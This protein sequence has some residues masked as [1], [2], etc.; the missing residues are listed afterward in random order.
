MFKWGIITVMG[1]S[2][3]IE[4]C[5]NLK[6][7]Q[8]D[9]VLTNLYNQHLSDLDLKI[10][11]FSVLRALWLMKTAAQ[12]QLEKVLLV[13]QATL[14]RSL[15]PLLRQ[16]Y[17]SRVQ[18]EKD[19]RISLVS[20]TPEGIAL[21]KQAET[22]WQAAQ[23]QVNAILGDDTLEKLVNASDALIALKQTDKSSG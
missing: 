13:D 11:Q 17:I 7:R 14:T 6:L 20:L 16:G 23:Q 22:R 9:R 1:G 2:M 18:D 4:P 5:F 21:Y 15:Q 3:D 10:T 12:K 8:A 19:R